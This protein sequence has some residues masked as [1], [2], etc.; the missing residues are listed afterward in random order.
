M[1]GCFEKAAVRTGRTWAHYPS[2]TKHSWHR[3]EPDHCSHSNKA[4]PTRE[5][6][7]HSIMHKLC[8][9]TAAAQRGSGN[10]PMSPQSPALLWEDVLGARYT[11]EYLSKVSH[12]LFLEQRGSL[13]HI[14]STS[15]AAP[16]PDPESHL[17]VL[18]WIPSLSSPSY[19]IHAAKKQLKTWQDLAKPPGSA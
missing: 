11:L 3:W 12:F 1:S 9:S 19:S 16:N 13:T 6:S 14:T 18:V 5:H 17:T 15:C 4:K 8:P 7:V 10:L 2:Y